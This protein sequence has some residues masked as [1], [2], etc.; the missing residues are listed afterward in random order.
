M[1]PRGEFEENGAVKRD[2][3]ER[4]AVSLRS[5]DNSMGCGETGRKFK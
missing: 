5:G 1:V 4:K 2:D 3:R